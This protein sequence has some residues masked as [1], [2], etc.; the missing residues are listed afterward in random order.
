MAINSNHSIIQGTG[1]YIVPPPHPNK[2]LV[3]EQGEHTH[4]GQTNPQPT[5]RKPN[6]SREY[7]GEKMKKDLMY[8]DVNIPMCFLSMM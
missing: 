5:T 8:H 3:K 7:H 4:L 2:W 1:N 6:T